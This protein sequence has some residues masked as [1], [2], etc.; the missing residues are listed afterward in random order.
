MDSF[1]QRCGQYILIKN[2][3]ELRSPLAS[4]IRYSLFISLQYNT[5]THFF[6]RITAVKTLS[7]NPVKSDFNI[8]KYIDFHHFCSANLTKLVN[9]PASVK[10]RYKKLIIK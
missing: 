2:G 8:L 10:V 3:Y 9:R 6:R 4:I 1:V 5:L 7:L